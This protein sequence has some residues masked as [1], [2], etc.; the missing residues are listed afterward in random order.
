MV[1]KISAQI[2]KKQQK[3]NTTFQGCL[4]SLTSTFILALRPEV[5]VRKT[6]QKSTYGENTN[7]SIE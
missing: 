7:D 6:A 5:T 3:Q 1:D 2:G 4:I